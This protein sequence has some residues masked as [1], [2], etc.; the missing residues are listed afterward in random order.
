MIRHH[1]YNVHKFSACFIPQLPSS[2]PS[3]NLASRSNW[4][5]LETPTN[6]IILGICLLVSA[7][8]VLMLGYFFKRHCKKRR[9]DSSPAPLIVHRDKKVRIQNFAFTVADVFVLLTRL[10]T[11]CTL[12]SHRVSSGMMYTFRR[13]HR[14]VQKNFPH[15]HTKFN[16]ILH[17][18]VR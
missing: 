9:R 15:V 8:L 11:C 5:E 6:M 18:Q 13:Q 4:Q 14:L 16:C 7:L 3:A 17:M 2:T 1:T 10:Y 12:L